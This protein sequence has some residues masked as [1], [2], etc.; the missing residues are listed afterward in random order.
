MDATLPEGISVFLGVSATDAAASVDLDEL[1]EAEDDFVDLLGEFSGRRQDD[2]LAL[3]GLGV[4]HLQ[5]SNGEGG[6]FASTRLCLRDGI[7]SAHHGQ[8]ALLLNDGG[9][10][11]TKG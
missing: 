2:G 7:L 11:K 4:E 10:F 6:S 8:D 9:F 1:A 3:G 5:H